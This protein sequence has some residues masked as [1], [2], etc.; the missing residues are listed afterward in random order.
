MAKLLE[1]IHQV[2]DKEPIWWG[3]L[4]AT[5]YGIGKNLSSGIKQFLHDIGE[6]EV[7]QETIGANRANER[8]VQIL[9]REVQYKDGLRTVD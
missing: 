1:C 8:I 9:K 6:E 7:T 3:K 5:F 4:H 2:S